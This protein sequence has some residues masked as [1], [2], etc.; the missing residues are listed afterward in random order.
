MK[1]RWFP[2]LAITLFF[3]QPPPVWAGNPTPE[4]KALLDRAMEIQTHPDL[5]GA[6]KRAERA[7]QIQKLISDS[8]LS[9]DMAKESLKDHWQDLSQAQRDE[10][11]NLFVILFQNSYTRMVLNF[12]R[13]EAI[14]YP[15][16]RTEKD[17]TV[18]Q[19]KIMRAN[20]HIPV[21]YHVVRRNGRWYILDVDIDGVS[22]V[23]NY[24]NTFRRF[25]AS[26][27]FDQLLQKMRL[28]SQAIEDGPGS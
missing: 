11:Q 7:Q 10:F 24:R 12:L 28:Q 13:K 16:V 27:S 3:L 2:M 6:G 25:V 1:T 9:T 14:E 4:V 17:G 22:I 20:E 18:V 5:Q 26:Q 8:F 23:G 21:D 15:G 19:T